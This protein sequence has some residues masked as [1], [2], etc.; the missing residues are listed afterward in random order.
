MRAAGSLALRPGGLSLQRQLVL[1]VLLP[2]L[3]LWMAGGMATYRLAV[4]YVNQAA[5]TTLL[6]AAH[7]LARQVKPIGDGVL[8]D[9]P[10][11][12]QKVL[13]ADPTDRYFY[14]I[15]TPPGKYILGNHHIPLPPAHMTPRSD[16]P[17]FYDGEIVQADAGTRPTKVR[18]TALYQAFGM[19]GGQPQ[20]M[21]VQVARSMATRANIWKMILIDTLLPLSGLILLMTMI[22]WI[23]TG[24]GLVPLLRLRR[25]V[26]G[27]SPADLT[28][29][30]LD[31]AP[32]ELR[33]L[34]QALNDLL[35]SVRHSVEAQKRFIADAAHQLRTPLAGLKSQTELALDATSDPAQVAR[36]KLVHQSATRAAHLINRLLMLARAE[37]EA[38]MV[39]DQAPVELGALVQ[40]VVADMVPRALRAGA[41]LGMG[42][43]DGS[44]EPP[45]LWIHGNEMLLGEALV[46]VLE[47]AIEYAGRGSEI[48][49]RMEHDG[50]QALLCVSDTGPGISAADRVRV[51]DRFVRATDEGHGCGLGLAIVKEIITRHGGTIA[52]EDAQPH[53]LKVVMRLP[54]LAEAPAA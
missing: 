33:S 44:H 24:R 32:P 25:E 45:P 9:F 16:A 48:T 15:S 35:A 23:G 52:L 28:P 18:I 29:L 6:Q 41:D 40:N 13:E 47:N 42:E 37:P 10:I 11:A 2:Q 51:F 49:V 26:E 39:Q 53:G 43:T 46:N 17:Y 20:W 19:A 4:H 27:R 36:L 22:V 30:Q 34:V 54:L 31:A 50:A 1:W 14:T 5:D 7:T 3:V 21:L 38:A 8:I 12:A